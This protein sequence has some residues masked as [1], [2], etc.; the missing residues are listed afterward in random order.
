MPRTATVIQEA[1][2]DVIRLRFELGRELRTAR[3]DA[4]MSLR[5]AAARAGVSHTQ[6]R[7]IELGLVERLTFEQVGTACAAVGLRLH[8]RA[9][10]G[11]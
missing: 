4:G 1:I 8:A 10:P 6:L 11:T 7:R 3:L 5:T 9:V 2:A